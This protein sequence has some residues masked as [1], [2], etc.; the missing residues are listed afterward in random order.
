MRETKEETQGIESM[1]MRLSNDEARAQA[2]AKLIEKTFRFR[3]FRNF[4]SDA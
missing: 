4:I 3:G 2:V 1:L